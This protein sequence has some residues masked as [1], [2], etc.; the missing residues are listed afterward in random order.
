MSSE[1][2]SNKSVDCRFTN[3]ISLGTSDIEKNEGINRDVL[4]SEESLDQKVASTDNP[5][6]CKSRVCLR[7]KF[8][9]IHSPRH[10]CEKCRLE[11]C[12]SPG[13]HPE[14]AACSTIPQPLSASDIYPSS[15]PGTISTRLEILVASGND[16]VRPSSG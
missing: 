5:S 15:D 12:D 10:R 4:S 3:P 11:Y 13:E 8:S 1:Q 7:C 6:I 2:P 9:N 16:K 14:L